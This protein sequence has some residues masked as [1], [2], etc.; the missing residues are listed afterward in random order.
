MLSGR[1][2]EIGTLQQF[3]ESTPTPAPPPSYAA[4]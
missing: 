3:F 4:K 1:L 2:I